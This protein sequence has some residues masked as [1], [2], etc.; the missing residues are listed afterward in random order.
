MSIFMSEHYMSGFWAY[1]LFVQSCCD[2]VEYY[3]ASNEL[4]VP[5]LNLKTMLKLVLFKI[6]IKSVFP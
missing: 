5:G 2:K 4:D 1:V 3:V 6:Q